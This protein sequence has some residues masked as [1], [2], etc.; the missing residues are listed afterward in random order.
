[1]A[2]AVHA[3]ILEGRMAEPVVG[4]ALLRI[5][6]RLVGFADFLELVLAGV[7]AGIAVRMKLHR[8]LAESSF[9]L[10]L[11]S[12]LLDPEGFVEISLHF[13]PLSG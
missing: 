8:E 7:V 1:M 13:F 11:V 2:A 3:A 5:L 10:L 12:A 9:Q 4:R 6:Q